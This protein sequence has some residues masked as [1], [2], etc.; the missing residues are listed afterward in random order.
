MQILALIP[1]LLLLCATVGL[2]V[3]CWRLAARLRAFNDVESGIGGSIAALSDRLDAMRAALDAATAEGDAR[4]QRLSDA[5]DA[6]DDRIGRLE[7]LLDSLDD[8]EDAL[9]QMS[10]ASPAAE[11]PLSFRAHPRRAGDRT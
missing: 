3:Y 10:P 4:L 9:A 6:A 11:A 1:D 5:T 8:A 7:M 2:A